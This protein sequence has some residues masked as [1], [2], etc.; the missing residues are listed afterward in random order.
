MEPLPLEADALADLFLSRPD[1]VMLDSLHTDDLGSPSSPV[2]A[3]ATADA[4]G[5][6]SLVVRG[7][8]HG[9][10]VLIV[11]GFARFRRKATWHGLVIVRPSEAT[12]A[13]L[14]IRKDASIVGAAI[15]SSSA[16]EA[17]LRFNQQGAIRYSSEA[18]N[19]VQT[20]LDAP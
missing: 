17:V 7:R 12:C 8:M 13:H 18:L 1:V 3:Y 10:G 16:G 14:T 6:D 5:T 9:Y 19:L 15:V 4:M 2:V 20:L 11:D